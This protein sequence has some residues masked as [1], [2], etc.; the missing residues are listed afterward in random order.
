MVYLNQVERD[1]KLSLIHNPREFHTGSFWI[2][3]EEY[4]GRQRKVLYGRTKRN[5][6][7]PGKVRKVAILKPRGNIK[8]RKNIFNET[9]WD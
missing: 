9:I 7:N 8:T 2:E 4:D 6:R 3:L 5:H 1:Y